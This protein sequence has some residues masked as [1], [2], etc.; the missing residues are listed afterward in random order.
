MVK[1][2]E[3][4]VAVNRRV[5]LYFER[6]KRPP[7]A[8]SLKGLGLAD[9]FDCLAYCNLIFGGSWSIAAL[10][11]GKLWIHCAYDGVHTRYHIT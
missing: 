10:L 4:G 3:K 11:L 6:V 9:E 1:Q 5:K 7:S 8:L 2:K